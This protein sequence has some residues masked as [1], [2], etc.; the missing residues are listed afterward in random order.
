MKNVYS[1]RYCD[2]SNDLH[3]DT[4]DVFKQY[5]QNQGRFR[6]LGN[7]KSSENDSDDAAE[8]HFG[9][10]NSLGYYVAKCVTKSA[11][12]GSAA[13]IIKPNYNPEIV[14]NR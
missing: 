13:R 2:F 14:N 8:M 7:A 5:W 3:L 1:T 9:D 11:A 6:V 10:H 4:P 12:L